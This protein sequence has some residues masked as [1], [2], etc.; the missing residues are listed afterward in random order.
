MVRP[1]VSIIIT[2]YNYGHFLADAIES[3][4][5]QTYKYKEIVVV[6]DGSTDNTREV[7]ATYPEVVYIY[8]HNQGLSAARNTGIT[9]SRGRYLVFLDADDWLLSDALNI[10]VAFLRN[11]PQA[12]FVAGSHKRVYMDGSPEEVKKMPIAPNPYYWLLSL[13][14]FIGMISTV[15]FT[16]WALSAFSFDTSLRNCEDYDL[17][18]NLTRHYPI[19]QHQLL[20]AAYRIHQASMSADTEKMLNGVQVVLDRQRQHI[21]SPLEIEGYSRGMECWTTYYAGGDDFKLTA[22]E[23]PSFKQTMHFFEQYA[24][25]TGQHYAL[26]H[27]PAKADNCQAITKTRSWPPQ[28]HLPLLARL[29]RALAVATAYFVPFEARFGYDLYWPV[30]RGYIEQFRQRVTPGLRGMVL[31]LQDPT[32]QEEENS[33]T[34][35][36]NISTLAASTPVVWYKRNCLALK[37]LPDSAFD[38]VIFT[39]TL[40]LAYNFNRLLRHCYRVLKPDGVLL[41]TV[42]GKGEWKK[43]W[44]W[45]FTA[46]ELRS[47][48]AKA[49]IKEVPHIESAGNVYV[50][51]AYLY[52]L[53]LSTVDPDKA[54]HYD[55]EYQIMHTVK[56]VKRRL[57]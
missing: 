4:L 40:H 39:H 49:F 17:Y 19:L 25:L 28:P 35:Q 15:M 10:G 29:Y 8:Q 51:V 37:E 12:A 57:G 30:E 55:P 53:A 45:S 41:L 1:V 47:Q 3:A 36:P 22:R 5:N 24:P 2:C 20:V 43:S 26:Y 42:P 48:L 9:R 14:N 18:L 13:G 11:H 21:I 31:D 54:D 23:L 50:A 44:Y 34:N 52:G 38:C 32:Y 16:R 56:V 7:V 27:Q 46:D 33:L 6:D